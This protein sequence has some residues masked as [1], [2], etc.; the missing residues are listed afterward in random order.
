MPPYNFSLTQWPFFSHRRAFGQYFI[1]L[2]LIWKKIC[3]RYIRV[4]LYQNVIYKY[5]K[6]IFLIT[7]TNLYWNC[8]WGQ[9]KYAMVAVIVYAAM[10][11]AVRSYRQAIHYRIMNEDGAGWGHLPGNTVMYNLP[12]CM[13]QK[14][15]SIPAKLSWCW[16]LEKFLYVCR[17]KS[18]GG[19]LKMVYW[20]TKRCQRT[21]IHEPQFVE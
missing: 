18:G 17:R 9:V 10:A 15:H 13:P 11:V 20:A 21:H 12:R 3:I 2:I 16:D 5:N 4:Y 8:R 19:F 14:R 1:I 7:C 6:W